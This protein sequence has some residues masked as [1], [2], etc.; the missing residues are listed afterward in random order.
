MQNRKFFVALLAIIVLFLGVFTFAQTTGNNEEEKIINE[1]EII[2]KEKIKEGAKENLEGQSGENNLDQPEENSQTLLTPNRVQIQVD[3]TAPIITIADYIKTPT[4]Q[5][6]VVT[7]TTNEG[8]LNQTT[9][10]F[11]E[12]GSF[13]FIATDAAGN[14]SEKEIVINNIDKTA[15]II[16]I[17]DY[18]TTPTNQ[19]IIVSASTNEGTLNTDTHL[20]TE[21]GS[22]F[23]IAVDVAGNISLE[24]VTINNIDKIAPVIT[25]GDYV[26]TPTNQD[27]VVSA[28]TNEGTLNQTSY[29]FIENGSFDFIAT[30]AS[31]NVT[32]KT[33]TIDN[34]DKIFPKFDLNSGYHTTGNIIINVTETNLTSINVYNQDAKTNT[35][36]V[37]GEILT[38]EATYK[39]TA[40]DT[41]GNKTE[42]WVAIDQT[43]PTIIGVTNN[44]YYN[45]DVIVKVFDKF[46]TKVTLNN[47]NKTPISVVGPNKENKELNLIVSD[48]G[49]YTIVGTDKVGNTTTIIFTIDKTAPESPLLVAPLDGASVKGNSITNSWTSV[50]DAVKYIYESYHNVTATRLRHRQTVN[51]PNHSKTATN[52]GD[53]IFWWRVKSV[54]AAGNESA[55]SDLRKVTV[56][57]TKPVITLN[58]DT[59]V[60]LEVN[61][62]Y[63]DAGVNITDNYDTGLKASK[64]S[65][66]DMSV[67]GTYTVKYNV[68]DSA[69]NIAN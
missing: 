28:T 65:T 61:T 46:L 29:T 2:K 17:G 14:K 39:I 32:T 48:E 43:N 15:P 34:I 59:E 1:N 18:T 16:T 40:L 8:T 23:F 58:G 66:V 19:D 60:T 3:V 68:T 11:I 54:D 41:A 64:T 45:K 57:S 62:T 24:M 63:N 44:S 35:L 22:F 13:T 67:L 52:I 12:N 31:G 36:V 42:I 33:V 10:T 7:A 25:I 50:P 56:D 47:I 69:G 30:D 5:T 9:Y 4:N 55:W 27:V 37:N 38:S 20:F 26:I 6:I 21:N 49:V 51:A 53:G